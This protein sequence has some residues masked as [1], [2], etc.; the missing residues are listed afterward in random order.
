MREIRLRVRATA[1]EDVL[2][3]LLLL[4][5]G[6]VRERPAGDDVVL[7]MR[8]P[9]LPALAE[10]VAAAGRRRLGLEECEVPD[11]WRERRLLDY[12]ADPIGGRL[13]VRPSWAP[14]PGAGVI[15]IVLEDSAAF[16]GGTHPTTRTC[17][18]WLLELAPGG[19]FADLGC[20]TGVL[21]ILAAKLGWTPVVAVDVQPHSLEAAGAN[22][23]RNHVAVDVRAIDLAAAPPPPA[24]GFAANV[25]AELHTTL[26]AGWK[27]SPPRVGVVSGFGP[28]EAAAVIDSYTA[29]GLREQRRIARG[30]WSVA[31][32]ARDC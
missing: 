11:D 30:G 21:A 29:I 15:D 23:S 25:P 22:A 1:V 3:R 14:A 2:D 10:I 5:P 13:I 6:G 24:D 18:E 16:G 27:A 9:D 7:V 28:S 19:A 26:A 20:G 8:G 17:L 12:E 31:L 32:V 4:V